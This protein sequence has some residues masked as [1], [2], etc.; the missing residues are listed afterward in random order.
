MLAYSQIVINHHYKRLIGLN[1]QIF[2]LIYIVLYSRD[3]LENVTFL[4]IWGG[5]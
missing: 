2:P 3:F 4:D 5:D 1:I